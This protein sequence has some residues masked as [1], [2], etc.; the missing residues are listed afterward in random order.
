MHAV[1]ATSYFVPD[2]ESFKIGRSFRALCPD[3]GAAVLVSKVPNGGTVVSERLPGGQLLKHPCFDRLSG[4]KK[5]SA[6]E[7]LDLFE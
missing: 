6:S 2:G 7:N 3:C 4:K 1:S 5:S